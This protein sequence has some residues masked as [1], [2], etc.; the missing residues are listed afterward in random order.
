MSV[1]GLR[2]DEE[3]ESEAVA[4]VH[5]VDLLEVL[6]HPQAEGRTE[7]ADADDHVL[8]HA[9]VRR[10]SAPEPR[11]ARAQIWEIWGDTVRRTPPKI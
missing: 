10:C 2:G 1:D 9:R 8:A 5:E 6:D 3:E 4:G 7:E 11:R